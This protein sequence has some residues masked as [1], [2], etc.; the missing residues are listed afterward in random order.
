MTLCLDY[1]YVMGWVSLRT[2]IF[3]HFWER[4]SSPILLLSHPRDPRYHIIA[5]RRRP[6]AGISKVVSGCW[7]RISVDITQNTKVIKGEKSIST[8]HSEYLNF[9]FGTCSEI[10]I[11]VSKLLGFEIFA[12]FWGVSE[13]LVSERSLGKKVSVSENLV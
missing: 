6:P 4:R 1:V 13:N 11:S 9:Y 10:D 7:F 3:C 2:S 5:H 8:S 12:N